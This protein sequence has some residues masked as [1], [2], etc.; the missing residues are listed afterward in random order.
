MRLVGMNFVIRSVA[1]S[2]STRSIAVDPFRTQTDRR[3]ATRR[4]EDLW[5]VATA[6]IMSIVVSFIAVITLT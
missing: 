6:L 5:L 4:K 3:M 1:V 2:M